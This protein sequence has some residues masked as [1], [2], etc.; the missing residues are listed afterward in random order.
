MRCIRK[1]RLADERQHDA[2]GHWSEHNIFHFVLIASCIEATSRC[3]FLIC[4][5]ESIA[6]IR[7]NS[8]GPLLGLQ[9]TRWEFEWFGLRECFVRAR[10][11]RT[12]TIAV[13]MCCYTKRISITIAAAA[14]AAASRQHS[15]QFFLF[16]LC[17]ASTFLAR[18]RGNVIATQRKRDTTHTKMYRKRYSFFF[19]FFSI[20]I[21]LFQCGFVAFWFTF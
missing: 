2:Y 9:R 20:I 15:L 19:S 1:R 4:F 5:R 16:L 21:I 10:S 13:S 3:A 6:R 18:Y 14:A 7:V 11:K 8:A 17:C 12:R